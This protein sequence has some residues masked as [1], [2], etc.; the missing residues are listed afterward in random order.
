MVGKK[1]IVR[2]TVQEIQGRPEV[3][4]RGPVRITRRPRPY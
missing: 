4:I 3:K 1:H 2:I